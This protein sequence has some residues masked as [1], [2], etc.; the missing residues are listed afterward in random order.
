MRK[1][2]ACVLIACLGQQA[3]ADVSA[4]GRATVGGAPVSWGAVSDDLAGSL[5][6]VAPL[7]LIMF[8]FPP[9]VASAAVTEEQWAREAARQGTDVRTIK[10]I[11]G[12][13]VWVD[14]DGNLASCTMSAIESGRCGAVKVLS[15]ESRAAAAQSILEQT[16]QCRWMGFDPALNDRATSM[17]G[18]A[19][20]TL[21]VAADCR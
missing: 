18:A 8:T 10:M 20:A 2:L 4:S 21:W 9:Q 3:M 5:S 6:V 15:I 19:S 7:S 12:P 11:L 13:S 16:G 1:A 17:A 14:A